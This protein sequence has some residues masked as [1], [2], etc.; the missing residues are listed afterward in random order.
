MRILL[1]ADPMLTVPPRLYGGIE[2]IVAQLVEAF[3]AEG[4]EVHLI[5][6][7]GSS[8]ESDRTYPWPAERIAG[9][10]SVLRNLLF[11]RSVVSQVQPDIVHSFA[12]LAFLGGILRRRTPKIMS[13]QRVPG[14]RQT[15]QA[16]RLARGS[17]TF[18][19]CSEHIK[20]LGQQAGTRWESIH[21]FVDTSLFNF[22]PT[23]RD[24]AP[25]V[26]LSR[27]DEVKGADT[28]IAIAHQTERRLIIA[29]NRADEGPEAKYF[30]ERVQPH[31][32]GDKIEWIGPVDDVQK[33]RLLGAAAAMLVPIRWHEPFGIVFAESL[34]CGT[35]VISSPMGALPE[36]V[37]AGINGFLVESVADGV[38]AVHSLPEISREKCRDTVI[39][40]FSRE[41]IGRRYLQ[42]YRQRIAENPA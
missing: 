12:R 35:P 42:L 14:L 36:I 25:L 29:G 19:G 5:A 21:N 11:V 27:L 22:V 24:D 33:N 28:A 39:N 40:K 41:V 31:I 30:E 20:K 13:Y 4:H 18:T 8:V 38:K 7:R 26:F 1:I 23:V 6:L 17:L 2:R 32:D 15:A 3:R 34:A 37:E 10:M 9:T 16:S